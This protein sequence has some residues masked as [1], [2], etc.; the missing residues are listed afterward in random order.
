MFFLQC[1]RYGVKSCPTNRYFVSNLDDFRCVEMDRPSKCCDDQ[2][3]P[4]TCLPEWVL[5]QYLD[6]AV[7]TDKTTCVS[8]CDLTT[9]LFRIDR[10][11]LNPDSC[12]MNVPLPG[13][14]DEQSVLPCWGN[15][16]KR[17]FPSGFSSWR[18][19][20][21]GWGHDSGV[22]GRKYWLH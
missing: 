14:S 20:R 8:S 15:P 9:D 12:F 13:S 17:K 5:A 19:R 1:F 4:E 10:S 3:D 18:P 2:N 21:I 16:R 22:C 6:A 7:Q 11:Y